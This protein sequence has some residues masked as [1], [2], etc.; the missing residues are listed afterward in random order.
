[1]HP[2]ERL[3]RRGSYAIQASGDR[4]RVGIYLAHGVETRSAAIVGFDAR[5]IG[6]RQGT[7]G[8]LAR[9]ERLANLGEGRVNGEAGLDRRCRSL[10]PCCFGHACPSVVF[11]V[12]RTT[13]MIQ[14]RSPQENA[15]TS[16]DAIII[17]TGQAG[18]AL[19]RRLAGSGM[20]GAGV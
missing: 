15:M 3:A 1:R 5:Q 11:V 10:S 2:G 9:R 17:G 7:G 18:P 4:Q 20:K 12:P 14:S 13:I 6:A 19:A 8:D 16:Y